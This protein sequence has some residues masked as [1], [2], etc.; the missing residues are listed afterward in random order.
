MAN[1][2]LA[3]QITGAAAWNINA[4]EADILDYDT[5]FKQPA[6]QAL[7]ERNEF[8]SSDHD[9]VIVGID[10]CDDV[11]PSIRVWLTRRRLTPANH[12]YVR[13][14]AFVHAWDDVDDDP[15]ITLVS[16][17]SDEPDNG[18]GDGNTVNDIVI[19]DD[20]SFLLRAERSVFGDGRTYTVTYQAEDSCGNVTTAEATVEV[21]RWSWPWWRFGWH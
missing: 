15:T 1:A 8:R 6:Q 18:P 5:S 16:V 20:D 19:L 7:Y 12:R 9:P 11:A 3:S 14:N 17:T 2:S 21:P 10:P 13:V 4:D